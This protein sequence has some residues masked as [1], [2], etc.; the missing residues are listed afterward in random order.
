[1]DY[2]VLTYIGRFQPFHNGHKR[3]IDAALQR[4][5]RVAIV[6]GSHDKPRDTRDPW[7]T[8][9]RIQMIS[10]CFTAE[11]Q[12]RFVFVPQVDHTYNMDRW[13]GG[14]ESSV[15]SAAFSQWKPDAYKIGII[16]VEK[17]W[18]SFYLSHFPQWERIPFD[19]GKLINAT[20]IR[21]VYFDKFAVTGMTI[22]EIEDRNDALM[23]SM[24]SY[25]Q[26]SLRMW[27]TGKAYQ[28]LVAET[29][30]LRD[31]RNN[32]GKGPFQTADMLV[33]QAGHVL[34]IERG[35]E[36]GAGLMALPGGFVGNDETVIDGAVREL[37]EETGLAVG[38]KTLR[39]AIVTS[40]MFDAPL[41]SLRGRI[42][43]QCYLARLHGK[44]LPK[45]KGGDDAAAA[46]WV[47]PGTIR[48]NEMFEDHF[49]ILE[50]M[51]VM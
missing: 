25:V 40:K 20:D 41:R 47:S 29:K 8:Q 44:E 28:Q 4:A 35:G 15:Y 27:K 2:D 3:V 46:R 12:K 14:V 51:G 6:I 5:D 9:E 37:F 23:A 16:G 1:M 31:Y 26:E 18:T 19:P 10:G 34:L 45:I 24:P 33:V 17:D 21:K 43:T 32:W 49:D 13:L 11:E 48:R 50:A 22:G 42:I 30:F 39:G 7:S 36:Y 38:E